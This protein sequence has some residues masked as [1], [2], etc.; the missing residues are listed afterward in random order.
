MTTLEVFIQ[1]RDFAKKEIWSTKWALWVQSKPKDSNTSNED[2]YRKELPI[3]P[4][5]RNCNVEN[6]VCI[7]IWL[8][9][10]P[11]PISPLQ[12]RSTNP[13]RTKGP[14]QRNPPVSGFLRPHRSHQPFP[15]PLNAYYGFAKTHNSRPSNNY[16]QQS[17]SPKWFNPWLPGA[18]INLPP[19]LPDSVPW[20]PSCRKAK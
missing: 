3:F 13:L 5:K 8:P 6:F 9:N 14:K 11:W 10:W 1:V 12:L 4:Q 16:N 2:R 18:T 7:H 19:H 15:S 17:S 20:A